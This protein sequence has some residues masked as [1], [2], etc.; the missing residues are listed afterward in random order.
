MKREMK[1]KKVTKLVEFDSFGRM[2]QIY[3]SFFLSEIM[4]TQI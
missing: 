3:L 1:K 4:L 2:L